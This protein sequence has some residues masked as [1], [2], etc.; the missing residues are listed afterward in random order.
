MPFHLS[1]MLCTCL[2][3][4]LRDWAT[5]MSLR[6]EFKRLASIGERGLSES[7]GSVLVL[8]LCS[9]PNAF[10]TLSEV[11]EYTRREYIP[12]HQTRHAGLRTI[13]FPI[14]QPNAF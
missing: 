2:R 11:E 1:H 9:G 5:G 12:D 6:H 4:S 10:H 14:G 7:G 8:S 3:T 13:G